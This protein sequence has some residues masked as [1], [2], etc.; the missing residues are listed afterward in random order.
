MIDGFTIF[1]IKIYF[2]ALA[3]VTGAFA[4]ALLASYRAKRRGLSSDLVWDLLPWLLLGGILGARLHHILLPSSSDIERGVT[5]MFYLS[6]PLDAINLR[7][8]GLGIAGGVLGGAIA[9][10]LFLRKKHQRFPVWADIIAPGLA[11]AQGIGRWGNFFNQELYGFPTSL[12]WGLYI[13]P[14]KRVAPFTEQEY[15]HPLFFYEFLW[16]LLNMGFLLWL[17]KRLAGKLKDGDLFLV[18]IIFYAIGRFGLEFLRLDPAPLAGL[19]ANQLMMAVA[20]TISAVLLV[21]RHRV[22]P[23]KEVPAS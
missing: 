23:A 7:K 12:P 10:W 13:P 11:L 17:D 22:Q 4:A 3:I 1:G 2:Y 20:A 9:S 6:H 8:G 19:N 18:Y 14:E 15:Y 21:V 5:T 16:N